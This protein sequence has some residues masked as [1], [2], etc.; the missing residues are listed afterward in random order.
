MS[1]LHM[2][3]RW[4]APLIGFTLLGLA[5]GCSFPESSVPVAS[6]CSAW[7]NDPADLHSNAEPIGLGCSNHLNLRSMLERPEDL[8]AGRP[9]GPA[10]GTR[11]I[12][13]VEDY[14]QGRL[15]PFGPT[16]P[17]PRIATPAAGGG[18]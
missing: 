10:D 17:E 15:A 7:P 4:A 14:Q 12:K 18:Q 5:S 11:Q 9:L 2:L 13:A 1:R 16:S 8:Q 3:R 6:P